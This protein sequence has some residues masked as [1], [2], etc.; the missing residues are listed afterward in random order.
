MF[1]WDMNALLHASPRREDNF[2]EQSICSDKGD[3]LTIIQEFS[4][5]GMYY[6][7]KDSDGRQSNGS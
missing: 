5:R 2:K 6:L 3:E 4:Q 1:M 7:G